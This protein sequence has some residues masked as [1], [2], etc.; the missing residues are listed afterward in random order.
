MSIQW[1]NRVVFET[2]CWIRWLDSNLYRVW[3]KCNSAESKLF[4]SGFRGKYG[5]LSWVIGGNF[6]QG[7]SVEAWAGC[8]KSY[9]GGVGPQGVT[10][11]GGTGY[12]TQREASGEDLHPGIC[13]STE[14]HVPSGDLEEP[15]RSPWPPCLPCLWSL[16]TT[17]S[18]KPDETPKTSELLTP[19]PRSASKGGGRPAGS[20]WQKLWV[21]CAFPSA[22]C[23][24]LGTSGPWSNISAVDRK[25]L[26][27]VAPRAW[28][29]PCWGRGRS[30]TC[31]RL[32]CP[33]EAHKGAPLSAQALSWVPRFCCWVFFTFAVSLF[34]R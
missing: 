11:K 33:P 29:E 12:K 31:E 13:P 9:R 34:R 20:C 7:L 17:S 18:A 25:S 14:G 16:A 30:S 27:P 28:P 22:S 32:N 5:T 15:R 3:E 21:A 1:V 10:G 2:P 6:L 26:S 23:T 8:G 19:P 24:P 4:H